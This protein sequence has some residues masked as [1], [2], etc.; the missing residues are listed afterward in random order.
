MTGLLESVEIW[1][2]G[3]PAAASVP[4]VEPAKQAEVQP[5]APEPAPR[6]RPPHAPWRAPHDAWAP[7]QYDE[8]D[9][10]AVKAL[11]SGTA[12]AGQQ[13]TVLT[14]LIYKAA[15]TYDMPF[16][17]GGIDGKRASDFACGRMFVGQQ[18]LKL[19]NMDLPSKGTASR[20]G[21]S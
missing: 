7:A 2:L 10:M 5:S 19:I 18:F 8:D 14:F 6:V 13:Q 15:A 16:R 1:D 21:K 3:P 17:P 20:K 12:S 11:A 4:V 9:I